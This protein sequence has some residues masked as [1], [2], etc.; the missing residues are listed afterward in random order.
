MLNVRLL[1][2]ALLL[3]GSFA[4]LADEPVAAP[5]APHPAVKSRNKVYSVAD[6]VV[7]IRNDVIIG[8]SPPVAPR[9]CED[10]LIDLITNKV[11]PQCWRK[12]GG[13]CV[14]QFYPI[15]MGL[16]VSGPDDVQAEVAATLDSLRQSQ[17]ATINVGLQ[18][19]TV[20]SE[21]LGRF[22]LDKDLNIEAWHGCDCCWP[23]C[24][25]RDCTDGC[26]GMACECGACCG[27]CLEPDCCP[28][29][30]PIALTP[31]QAKL[32]LDAVK[33]DPLACIT[34]A[35]R[36]AMTDGQSATVSSQQQQLF[37]TGLKI[38]S[39]DGEVHAMPQVSPFKMGL[40]TTLHASASADRRSI[41]LH[42]DSNYT[43]L[44][45]D[46][47]PMSTVHVDLATA[48]DH[49]RDH[50]SMDV[51]HAIQRPKFQT[52]TIDTDL[53]VHS[54]GTM[55][56]YGGR[57]DRTQ[58]VQHS[59]PLLGKIPGLRQL[60]TH[61][62]NEP[63]TEHLLVLVTPQVACD[64]PE[65]STGVRTATFS[66]VAQ[67]CTPP[68]CSACPLCTGGCS[69]CP[70]CP[71][72]K[73]GQPAECCRAC[74]RRIEPA[75]IIQI[76]ATVLPTIDKS[77]DIVRTEYPRAVWPQSITGQFHVNP[78]GT[79]NL[80]IYGSVKV[81]GSTLDEARQSIHGFLVNVTR[82]EPQVVVVWVDAVKCCNNPANTPGCKPACEEE[83]SIPIKT[84]KSAIESRAE[85]IAAKIVHQYQEACAK[86][87]AE[88]ARLIAREALDLDPECF[89]KPHQPVPTSVECP[90]KQACPACPV[91]QP[92]PACPV[93]LPCPERS[94]PACP[95]PLGKLEIEESR[96]ENVGCK[97]AVCPD[98]FKPQCGFPNVSTHLNGVATPPLC[99]FQFVR[100][101]IIACALPNA[102]PCFTR[103]DGH[104]SELLAICPPLSS[105]L[106]F[107]VFNARS[108]YSSCPSTFI[109]LPPSTLVKLEPEHNGFLS[110][111]QFTPCVAP[112][113]EVIARRGLVD[114]EGSLTSPREIRIIGAGCLEVEEDGVPQ[115]AQDS[116]Q[117]VID[118]GFR[119]LERRDSSASP[120]LVLG[121]APPRSPVDKPEPVRIHDVIIRNTA[122]VPN[123]LIRQNLMLSRLDRLTLEE[124][125]KASRR[126]ADWIGRR[127]H[128]KLT[129]SVVDVAD[130]NF[131]DLVIE[132]EG[133][134]TGDF[135]SPGV[136]F[137][138]PVTFE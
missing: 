59:I 9:T 124:V 42:L 97:L 138:L 80:G 24:C 136:H 112:R 49:N 134:W 115:S 83:S 111:M 72:A 31:R 18:F 100:P 94:A 27:C 96:H 10:R 76:L 32:L 66:G 57:I 123:E 51:T 44:E 87:D 137:G 6:L 118:L 102:L 68:V 26:A 41:S 119:M 54:G 25:C 28:E 19:M 113:I 43:C 37:V 106:F 98:C 116:N 90:C 30:T 99:M 126:L 135:Y 3:A 22:G 130:S 15:G 93:V 121:Q 133:F 92:C 75:D 122:F 131:V 84:A 89:S 104:W 45:N 33:A 110:A 23:N 95:R 127:E 85:K 82:L 65:Q 7:P 56:V 78:D 2:A 5:N 109:S 60:F 14:I 40:S 132:I 86:G 36:V 58:R 107:A 1:T 120:P 64:L 88:G 47:V 117:N 12:A 62:S 73:C 108:E 74:M 71:A 11:Q 17:D 125:K 16:V 55:L 103:T 67:T 39:V 63:A 38:E 105:P 128:L 129:V 61:V 81:A 70:N 52:L 91:M 69:A 46:E 101:E 20:S 4:L 35:P 29:T 48:T 21:F 34:D 13:P 77:G 8:Q 53:N 114:I 50:S 79:V